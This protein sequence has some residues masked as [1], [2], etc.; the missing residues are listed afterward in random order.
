[1][2]IFKFNKHLSFRS[3]LSAKSGRGGNGQLRGQNRQT[4]EELSGTFA[5][6]MKPFLAFQGLILPLRLFGRVRPPLSRIVSPRCGRPTWSCMRVAEFESKPYKFLAEFLPIFIAENNRK[7]GVLSFNLQF[8]K[9]PLCKSLVT[10]RPL[11]CLS[12]DSP[13]CSILAYIV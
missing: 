12:P 11:L 4:L 13:F 1:M 5:R 7:F 3:Q 8:T 10:K 2:L 9:D 6:G